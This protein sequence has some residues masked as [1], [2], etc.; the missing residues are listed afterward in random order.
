MPQVLTRCFS[1]WEAAVIGLLKEANYRVTAF[2]D[3][4]PEE[5]DLSK[6]S[7]IHIGV[8]QHWNAKCQLFKIHH[9]K[10]SKP[11]YK[12]QVGESISWKDLKLVFWYL[13]FW[14]PSLEVRRAYERL[15]ESEKLSLVDRKYKQPNINNPK[16]KTGKRHNPEDT[17]TS[18]S[19][20]LTAIFTLLYFQK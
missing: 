14:L 1:N 5:N 12:P 15:S 18:V 19:F 10:R 9:L 4:I 8:I 2:L 6:I 3:L 13:A 16:R 11:Y 20:R 17:R 7:K